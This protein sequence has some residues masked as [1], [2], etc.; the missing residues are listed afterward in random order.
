MPL[1]NLKGIGD[2]K[3]AKLKKIGLSTYRDVLYDFPVRYIDR[4]KI[5]NISEA[6]DQVHVT[7]RAKVLSIRFKVVNKS[8]KEIMILEVM[9]SFHHGEIVFFSPQYIQSFFKTNELYYFFGKIEKMGALFKMMHPEYARAD[10]KL[11]LSIL[12]VYASTLGLYQ[13]DLVR[14]HQQVAGLLSPIVEETL[15]MSVT[16]LGKLCTLQ[17]ALYQIHHPK[18][19][20]TLKVARY[21]LIYEELFTLQLKLIVLKN[22]YHRAKADRLEMDQE[23]SDF[24]THLPFKLTNAQV[25]AFEDIKVDLKSGNS[26]NRLIQGDVGSGKTILAFLTLLMALRN[27]KQ[28]VLMAP[29]A[30]LARQHYESFKQYFGEKYKVEILDSGVSAKEKKRVKADIELGTVD[31]VIG[32]HAV[33]EED[34]LFKAL[35]VVITDEQH[36]FGVRQRTIVS[37]KGDNPHVLIMSATPIP[38]TL[39]LI[40]YGD[41]DVSIVDEMPAGRKPI[42][43]HFVRPSKLEEM[44]VFIREKLEASRQVYFVCPLVE[45]SETLDL[46]SATAHYEALKE[47]FHDFNVGIV[48]GKMKTK[49]KDLIMESFKRNEINILVSTTVIEVGINVPNASVMVILNSERFGLSQLHQL[50]GRVGRGDEQSYCFLLSEKLSKDAKARIETMVNETSGFEIADKDLELRGS[51]EVFGVRQHGLPE[52]K[53]ADLSKHKKILLEAQKHVKIVIAEYQLGNT[54]MIQY[55][56]KLRLEINETFTL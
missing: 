27:Q 26:M 28:G 16:A 14:L 12:P 21:R 25:K 37:Q 38:R 34:V 51:G 11:F 53:L 46:T 43:T 40:L 54:E 2:K 8:K 41:M 7:I 9:D 24:M 47:R 20:Q 49:E 5:V 52:L 32:T 18:D 36:R 50:R 44:Y 56:D 13:S 1:N 33:L 48:H 4:R 35:G 3:A 30:I 31:V 10:D 17:D 19:E 23:V 45:D 15:P 42:K 55:I 6:P 29:T 22:N 39:S